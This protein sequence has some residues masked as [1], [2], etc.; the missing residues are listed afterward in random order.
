MNVA[1]ILEL[2]DYDRWATSRVFGIAATLT[3][4]Q[5]RKPTAA[6]YGSVFGTLAHLAWSEWVWLRRWTPDVATSD[7]R[8]SRNLSELQTLWA[9]FEPE[10]RQFLSRLK[11]ADLAREVSYQ[12]PPGTTWSYSLQHMLQHVVNHSTY[13]RGQLTTLFREVG[14]APLPV[15][16][17][18]YFDELAGSGD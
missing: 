17:L 5:L 11:D 4:E 16:F 18:V 15:D 3:E 10:Q 2:Y 9:A 7:P 8:A 14:V 1:D 13:H 6:S 12:N